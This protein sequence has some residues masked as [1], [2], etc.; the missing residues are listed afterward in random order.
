MTPCEN[1][2]WKVGEVFQYGEGV[3]GSVVVLCQDDGTLSPKFLHVA[4]HL[5]GLEQYHNL[6]LIKHRIYPPEEKRETIELMGKTYDKAEI[7]K[8]LSQVKAIS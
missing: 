2:N 4:G 1:R 5:D 6:N 7:E 8:A 3:I